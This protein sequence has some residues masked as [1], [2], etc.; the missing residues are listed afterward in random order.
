M[1]NVIKE[2]RNELKSKISVIDQRIERRRGANFFD[3]TKKIELL[4]GEALVYENVLKM[5]DK[6][7]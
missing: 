4:H 5:L 2:I 6:Y 7:E 1:T 3:E